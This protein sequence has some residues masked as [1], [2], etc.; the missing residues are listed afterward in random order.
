MKPSLPIWISRKTMKKPPRST[1]V[2][3]SLTVSLSVMLQ[4]RCARHSCVCALSF[5]GDSS[6]IMWHACGHFKTAHSLTD[7]ASFKAFLCDTAVPLGMRP[8]LID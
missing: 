6:H 5:P 8:N 4:G 3:V 1:P 2:P 7:S